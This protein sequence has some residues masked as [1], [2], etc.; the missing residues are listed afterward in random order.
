MKKVLLLA[1]SAFYSA[2]LFSQNVFNPTDA[3]VRYDK[4]KALGSAQ[5]PNPAK[6]GLQKW[7]ST[8]T[9]GV[10]TGS[11][12]FDASSF[13][14]YYLNV[15]SVRLAYRIKFPKTYTTDPTK[16]F[17][18]MLF[19]HGAGEV[20]C[21]SNGGVYNNEK[22]LW[23]GGK[24]FKDRVDNGSFDG[25]LVYPQL[26]TTDASCWGIWGTT[27][28]ANLAAT[29]SMIDSLA[30]YCRA[31]IDRVLVDGLSGGGYGAWRMAN[32]Y[33]T[34]IA[35]IMPSASAGSTAGRLNFVHIPIWFATGGKDPDPSPATAQYVLN[36]MKAVGADIRYTL[37]P[38]L[39]HGVWNN[40]W[41]EPDFVP[42]MNDM[43]KA[44]PL[45]FFQKY[46]F[47]A[48]EAVNVKIGISAG[49]YAYEWQKDNALIAS[50]INTTNTTIDPT[51]V[52]INA[53][54][55]ITVKQ[56]GTYR[57]RFRRT[58]SSPW[59]EWSPKPAVIKPKVVAPAPPITVNG[60][61]SKVL[62]APDGSTTVP[63]QMPAGF[64]NYDWVRVSDNVKVAST[65]IFN[66][67]VGVY[68]AKYDET[69]GCGPSYSPEFT[70]ISASGTPKPDPAT[71][72]TSSMLTTTSAKINWVGGANETGYEVYRS[73]VEGGP[74]TLLAITNANILTYTDNSLATNTTYY[75]IVRAVNNTGAAANSNESSPNGGNKAPEI[76]LATNM[77]AQTDE[78]TNLDFTVTDAVGDI[79]TVTIPSKPSFIT[80]E[81]VSG[82]SYRIVV[83][84]TVDQIGWTDVVVRAQDDKGMFSTKTISIQVSDKN[85]RS[86]YV[87][88]GA[89]GKTAPTP[90]NNWLSSKGAGNALY[91]LKDEN[92]VATS[93]GITTVNAWTGTQILGHITGNNSGVFPDAVLESG[94][95]DN[96]A[97]KQILFT[98]LNQAMRYNIIFAGSR[99]EGLMASATYTAGTQTSLLNARYN[100]EQTANLNGLIP[101]AL[102]Q[103]LVTIARSSGTYN[104]LNGLVIEEYSPELFLNP[105]NLF[106]EPL[107]RTTTNLTWSDKT[108]NETG[109]ELVRATDSLFT[110]N[111]TTISLGAN[112]TTYKNT[113]LS[114]NAKYWYRVRA[115]NGSESSDYSNRAAVI[116]PSSITYVNFNVAVANGP[117]PWNNLA[118]SPLAP[119]TTA[120]LKN[121]ANVTTNASLTLVLPFN[122]ENTA[123]VRTGNNSGICPDDVLASSYWIDKEQLAQFKINGLN[124]G[125]KY[126]IGFFG[127]MSTNGWFVGNYTAK[128]TI[129]GR[130]VYL[131]SWMNSTKIVYVGNITPDATGAV[132]LDFTTIAAA[133]W[134]FNG[135]IIIQEYSD[136]NG[137]TMMNS[138]I[139]DS[140]INQLENVSVYPNPFTDQFSIDFNNTNPGSRIN[141]EIYDLTGRL[142]SRT[143][144]N[145]LPGGHNILMFRT[146]SINRSNIYLLTLKVNGKI[147]HTEKLIQRK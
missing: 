76:T 108:N 145:Q 13:K 143:N 60:L 49:F 66:A 77:I 129:N 3:T 110:Q 112:V 105:E 43:H 39:G 114:A 113:G 53:G 116:T 65:Q 62:P 101:D 81:N 7:V 107:D 123:G 23:L 5:N 86:V 6:T 25:F 9:S 102:G 93:F 54:N 4:T 57:V 83:N 41:S 74:Y 115:K 11:S 38:S 137:G 30:K 135:G 142:V 50:R 72:L 91:S 106:V 51:V 48:G 97:A 126:R 82:T 1:V 95:A 27:P 61:E 73:T 34:R 104:Y 24:L 35:K 117:A 99:N 26:V 133:D 28:I 52:A 80:L 119:Y 8:P 56:F 88:F 36:Q 136:A 120:K 130:S 144:Y 21:P 2:I 121:Y 124:A 37:Y 45:V 16:K 20:G 111:V 90:W 96:G 19:L 84:P 98:G 29:L 47:C 42:A 15:N 33:P 92:N 100:T 128:Y 85:T 70:V 125:L 59:S 10:S 79:V 32:S 75:Y 118:S 134:G 17:P 78:T 14:A 69:P 31:D 94:L 141:A 55:D 12:T 40:H 44:N 147:V 127:S 89:G 58:I 131:N 132:T 64:I 103:I 138:V 68:K 22:Q 18:V 139:Q 109:F 67:P 46:E 63:L 140:V 146:P 122:G 87:N 71:T